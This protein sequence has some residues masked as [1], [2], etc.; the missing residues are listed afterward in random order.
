MPLVA[1]KNLVN[2]STGLTAIDRFCFLPVIQVF[3]FGNT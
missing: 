2:E 1:I 3:E